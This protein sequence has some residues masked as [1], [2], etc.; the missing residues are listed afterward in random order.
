MPLHQIRYGRPD[1]MDPR[2][3][4]GDEA[5]DELSLLWVVTDRQLP[6]PGLESEEATI[7]YGNEYDRKDYEDGGGILGTEALSRE[8]VNC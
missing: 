4:T 3:L 6:R 2:L 7:F 1:A 8:K 5:A